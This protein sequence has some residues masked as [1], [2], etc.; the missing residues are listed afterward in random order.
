MSLVGVPLGVFFF[1]T[2]NLLVYFFFL[3]TTN[4]QE[5]SPIN[6]VWIEEGG[7]G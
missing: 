2:P 6:E 4:A 7:K 1:P 3:L 5:V